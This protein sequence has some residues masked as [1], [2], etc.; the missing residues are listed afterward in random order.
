MAQ[1]VGPVSLEEPRS[2]FLTGVPQAPWHDREY[3]EET[4]RE[5]DCAVR[6]IVETAFKRAVDM[7]SANRERLERGAKLL[8]ERETLTES[9]LAQFR[10]AV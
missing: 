4:A 7:L 2:N 9:D 5:V 8:L 6:D 1:E 3:S 10:P